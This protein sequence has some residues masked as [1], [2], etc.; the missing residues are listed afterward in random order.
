[1]EVRNVGNCVFE[2]EYECENRSQNGN[3]Y[4]WCDRTIEQDTWDF[5]RR[6]G[7]CV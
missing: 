6:S 3:M 5:V 1:M 7:M 4:I 2:A